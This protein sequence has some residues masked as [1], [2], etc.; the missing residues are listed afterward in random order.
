MS[1]RSDEK[2]SKVELGSVQNSLHS[3]QDEST[4]KKME[5]MAIEK[6]NDYGRKLI[7]KLTERL[8]IG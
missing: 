7:L 1:S 2:M 8:C 6:K 3:H 4:L 5:E